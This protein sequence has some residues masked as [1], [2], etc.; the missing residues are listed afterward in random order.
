M[1]TIGETYH[2]EH[3]QVSNFLH[4]QN[5]TGEKDMSLGTV[6]KQNT[7]TIESRNTFSVIWFFSDISATKFLLW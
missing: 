6:Q 7:L 5:Y 2:N 4:L 3:G 1:Q